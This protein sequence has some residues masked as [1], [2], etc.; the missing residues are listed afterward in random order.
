MLCGFA[1]ENFCKTVVAYQLPE[2]KRARVKNGGKLP[3]DFKTHDLQRLCSII[4][5]SVPPEDDEL[6]KRLEIAAVWLGRYPV[7][8]APADLRPNVKGGR[9]LWAHTMGSDEITRS[10]Q[11]VQRVNSFARNS[12]AP[13]GGTYQAG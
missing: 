6:V 5:F 7:P 10:T 1:A 11:F 3:A 2:D 13:R 4:G 9:K 8:S 12:L